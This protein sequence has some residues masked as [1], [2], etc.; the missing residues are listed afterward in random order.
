MP[1]R[2]TIT[3]LPPEIREAIDRAIREGRASADDIVEMVNGMGAQVSASAVTRYARSAREQMQHYRQAQEIATVWAK[4]ME[5]SPQGDVAQLNLQLLSTLAFK[6][7]SDI[8]ERADAPVEAME[9]ML[10]AKALDHAAKAERTTLERD[11]RI[12]KE[13]AQA[14][15]ARAVSAAKKGGLSA[16]AV[17]IIRRDILG[18]GG[19]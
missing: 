14:A 2:S 9:M 12:R 7:L 1:R 10:L 18:L 8:N 5:E 15:A 11:L 17:D 13:V 19:A 16:D 6:V 3:Q 4:R